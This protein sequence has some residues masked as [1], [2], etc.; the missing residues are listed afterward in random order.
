MR[1]TVDLTMEVNPTGGQS[2][3]KGK[4][5]CLKLK[6]GGHWE[7]QGFSLVAVDGCDSVRVWWD[8]PTG[9]GQGSKKDEV[10][11]SVLKFLKQYRGKRFTANDIAQQV[12]GKDKSDR[13]L[14]GILDGLEES[15]KI[16]KDLR[17]PDKDSSPHNPFVYWY[18]QQAA[19]AAEALGDL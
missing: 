12:A 3:G 1:G 8:E 10:K 7:G 14:R 15:R 11:S 13:H 4:L 9:D 17:S 19:A 18:D 6:D 2:G 16:R 5:T